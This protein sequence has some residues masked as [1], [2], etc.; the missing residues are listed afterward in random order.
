MTGAANN[1]TIASTAGP[2]IAVAINAGA[3]SAIHGSQVNPNFV[4]QNVSTTGT[5]SGDGITSTVAT[6]NA[7]SLDNTGTPGAGVNDV[8][9]TGGLWYVTNL[10]AATFASVNAGG[11]AITN[12]GNAQIG[13]GGSTTNDFGT[14]IGATNTIGV[15]GLTQSSTTINGAL[16]I[17]GTVAFT[18]APTIPLPQSELFLGNASGDATAV[19]MGGDATIAFSGPSSGNVSITAS[20]GNDIVLAL[21]NASTTDPINTPV[22]ITAASLTTTGAVDGGSG[23]FT[24]TL[25]VT[26]NTSLSTVS[27]SGLATLNSL[28]TSNATISGG[29]IDNTPIGSTNP[30][31]IGV[32]TNATT[33][34]STNISVPASGVTGTTDINN[35]LGD[36]AG[37]INIGNNGAAG[38]TALG[39]SSTTN[40]NGD[41]NLTGNV[42][43]TWYGKIASRFDIPIFTCISE[44]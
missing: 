39:D 19:T 20:A 32:F 30:N 14:G 41:V 23:V 15:G 40:I 1:N 13:T 5:I 37:S 27:T 9:G 38:F 7:L 42:D 26:G 25:G 36:Y 24:G 18:T 16:N 8:T 29:T 28:T 6:G 22:G 3:A 44:Q 31:T 11:G 12:T 35:G 2:D 33:T 43:F 21:N 34:G 10:G 17:T 4:A